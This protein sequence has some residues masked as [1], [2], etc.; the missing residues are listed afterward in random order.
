MMLQAAM[1][2]LARA[3]NE[4]REMWVQEQQARQAAERQLQVA[5]RVLAGPASSQGAG[6]ILEASQ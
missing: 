5:Q 2:E 3:V 1:D 6:R 4:A